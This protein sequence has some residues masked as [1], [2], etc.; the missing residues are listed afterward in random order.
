M[1]LYSDFFLE[2]KFQDQPF[3]MAR[4]RTA[5]QLQGRRDDRNHEGQ[6]AMVKESFQIKHIEEERA[7]LDMNIAKLESDFVNARQFVTN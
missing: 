7:R 6:C 1:R 2:G 3:M 4:K 5:A